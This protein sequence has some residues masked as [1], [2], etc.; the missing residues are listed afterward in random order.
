MSF[1]RPPQPLDDKL[2]SRTESD[3]LPQNELN[4]SKWR[5]LMMTFPIPGLF[6][7]LTLV[8]PAIHSALSMTPLLAGHNLEPDYFTLKE[9]IVC[10]FTQVNVARKGGKATFILVGWA[11][12][13]ILA[14][15]SDVMVGAW[16]GCLPS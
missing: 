8:E 13:A 2:A 7:T 11:D 9:A 12:H 1:V 4:L 5:S 15:E 10:D 6:R 14:L 3:G 16:R